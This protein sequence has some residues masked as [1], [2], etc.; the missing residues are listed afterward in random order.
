MIVVYGTG[1]LAEM[2]VL[3]VILG[4]LLRLVAGALAWLILL[5]RLFGLTYG[6]I[7]DTIGLVPAFRGQFRIKRVAGVEV[8]KGRITNHCSAPGYRGS[9]LREFSFAVV[10]RI[11]EAVCQSP[12]R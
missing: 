11:D 4:F 8:R 10:S 7:S 2:F 6:K 3:D 5:P 1:S 12:R 9:D